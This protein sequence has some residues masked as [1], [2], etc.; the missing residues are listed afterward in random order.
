MKR[1]NLHHEMQRAGNQGSAGKGHREEHFSQSR[2]RFEKGIETRV[3][4]N[5]ASDT[6]FAVI[7]C[8]QGVSG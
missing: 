7:G 8:Y 4:S 3:S 1:R 2:N 5:P 6:G